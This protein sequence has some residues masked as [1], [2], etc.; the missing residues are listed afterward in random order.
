[1]GA[2]VSAEPRLN[3][4]AFSRFLSWLDGDVEAAALR[5]R[6]VHRRLIKV[7]ANRG[8]DHPEEVADEAIDRVVLKIDSLF[9]VAQD[10]RIA[11][12]QGV[13]NNV[14]REHMRARL[15][16]RKMPPRPETPEERAERERMHACLEH[17]LSFLSDEQRELILEYY[18]QGGSPHMSGRRRLADEAH[19]SAV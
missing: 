3:P 6:D 10:K 19:I 11:Y 9:T 18:G 7:V 13:A 1:M 12:I 8:C 14:V 4:E 2:A 5:Y 17:C 16:P 15:P